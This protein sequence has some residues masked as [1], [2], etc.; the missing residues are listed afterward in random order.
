MPRL[1]EYLDQTYLKLLRRRSRNSDVENLLEVIREK[2]EL[3]SRLKPTDTKRNAIFRANMAK[4][5]AKQTE[6]RKIRAGNRTLRRLLR[7]RRAKLRE[8]AQRLKDLERHVAAL[9]TPTAAFAI[10]GE[11]IPVEFDAS[12][13]KNLRDKFIRKIS[14]ISDWPW[15]YWMRLGRYLQY[16]PR[17]VKLDRIPRIKEMSRGWP[18][19]SIVTPSYQ[20]AD[21]L[22]ATLDSV[23]DQYYPN[24]EYIVMDG[25]ST[26]GSVDIIKSKADLLAHWESKKDGGQSA[27]I[28][29]G[30]EKSSGEIMAWLNSDDLIFPGTLAYVAHYFEKH[31]DVDV[32]YGQRIIIDENGYETGRWVLP[33]HDSELLTW[34]D[35]IPQECTFW[36]RSIYEKVGGMDPDFQFAMDWDLFSRFQQAGA[37][38]VRLPYF[39]GGFRIHPAQKNA[40]TIATDGFQEMKMIRDRILGERY[41]KGSLHKRINWMQAKAVLTT[42]L[43]RLGIRW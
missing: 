30:L 25:G 37:K 42:K 7:S 15:R 29:A 20:Q 23:L 19:I 43:L 34:A 41:Q 1:R 8:Q 18:E 6:V 36:R 27:A 12:P 22:E 16:D 28:G 11:T 21:F 40:T 5:R 39:M 24:L 32:V 26:D 9:G 2:D 17:P 4:W 13:A 35:F 10:A 33:R 3:I 31:P 38:F 14:D